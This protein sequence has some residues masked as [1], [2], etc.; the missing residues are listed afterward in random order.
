MQW[1]STASAESPRQCVIDELM[2]DEVYYFAY[3]S[4]MSLMRL[5]TRLPGAV[6]LGI[7]TLTE[8]SLRFHKVGKDGSAK[9]DARHTGRGLDTVSGVLYRI[10]N[11][12]LVILDRIEGRGK[13]Y[14][15]RTL[16]VTDST[17]QKLAAET[18]IATRLDS[19][20]QPF[21]WYLEH[22]LQ[23][24]LAAGLPEDYVDMIRAVHA[25][26]DPDTRRHARELEIY[27]PA[28]NHLRTDRLSPQP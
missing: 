4:N 28:G 26:R 18:Y 25:V 9:C 2:T 14:D 3:G 21:S 12:E 5:K 15:R 13:G 27:S 7:A 19:S 6:P 24:A 1:N 20:L 23:G 17:G 10:S 22:V 11:D 16:T 8:H